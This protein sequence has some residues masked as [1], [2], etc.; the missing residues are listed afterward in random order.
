LIAEI[1]YFKTPQPDGAFYLFPHVAQLYGKKFNGTEIKNS[2]DLCM[3]FLN[4]AHVALVSG[5][6]FGDGECLRISYATSE[7]KLIEAM[8]R[9]KNAVLKLQ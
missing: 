9:L 2:H 6:A 8:S 3:Y 5:D 1:P 4:E 7:E